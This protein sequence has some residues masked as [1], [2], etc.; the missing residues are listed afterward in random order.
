MAMV[1]R[2]AERRP[3]IL[4]RD[5]YQSAGQ[6]AGMIQLSDCVVS[7]HRS[8]GY[9]LNLADAMAVGT[10]V[11]ATGHSGNMTFMD[12]RS[13]FLVPFDQAE[14]GPGCEPYPPDATWVQPDLGMAAQTLRWVF[15]HPEDARRRGRVGQCTILQEN[16]LAVAGARPRELVLPTT[17]SG[18]CG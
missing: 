8:D 5:G 6:L 17:G 4:I 13:A 3:D 16:S 11:V 1:A 18:G 12:D 9:G 2:A 7:L 15:D 14:V 10:P